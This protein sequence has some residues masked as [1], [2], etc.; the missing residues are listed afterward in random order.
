MT[1]EAKKTNTELATAARL[2]AYAAAALAGTHATGEVV[3]SGPQNLAIGLGF[4]QNLDLDEGGTSPDVLLSNYSFLGGTYSGASVQTYPGQLVGFTS[5]NTGRNYVSLLSSGDLI[6]ATTV[7]PSFFGSMAY[8]ANNPEAEFNSVTGGFLGLSFPI[9]GA[10]H[11]GWVRV[12]VDNAASA[13]TIVDWAYESVA[14]EGINAGEVPEPGSL[15]LL[16][17]GAAGLI[18]RRRKTA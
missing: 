8:G 6:D 14:G 10:T 12:D 13:F 2:S 7:G 1:S 5:T 16:A 15:A 17:A 18:A 11:F 4:S 3:Y 9:S